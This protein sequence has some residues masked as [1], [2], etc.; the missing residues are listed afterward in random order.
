MNPIEAAVAPMKAEAV[1]RQVAAA[2]EMLNK[3][4]KILE[5]AGFNM[6]VVAPLPK[7]TLGREAYKQA[8]AK[9]DYF[10]SI[11]TYDRQHV[12]G[13]AGEPQLRF[14]CEEAK[15]RV[16]KLA[17]EAAAASYD[18]YVAKLCKKVGECEQAKV[19]GWLWN[20]SV[21]TVTKADGTVEK[22]ETQMIVNVSAL[23]K[24]FNQWPTRKMK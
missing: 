18:A 1:Q 7:S 13:R 17:E 19:A 6:D 8:K 21:L 22:W 24:L 10:R 14:P 15:A 23:G 4:Y 12:S 3:A 2:E 20:Y 16:L 11:T 5:E 9:R